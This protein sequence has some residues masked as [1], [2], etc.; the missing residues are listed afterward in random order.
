MGS[1]SGSSP[2]SCAVGLRTQAL[3]GK[4]GDL[5]GREAAQAIWALARLRRA[6][7]AAL[8][9]LVRTAK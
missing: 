1:Q 4:A 5:S 7:K 9:A 8:D 3:A 6:D 2:L